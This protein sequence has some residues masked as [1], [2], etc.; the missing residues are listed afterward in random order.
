M[1]EARRCPNCAD[2]L[3][4]IF[5]DHTFRCNKCRVIVVVSEIADPR[6]K[7]KGIVDISQEVY[8]MP[9]LVRRPA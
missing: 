9:K 4:Y 1:V 7:I 3:M 5:R 6:T 2:R 8:K